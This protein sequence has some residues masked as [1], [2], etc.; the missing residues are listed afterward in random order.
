MDDDI[1]LE[2]NDVIDVYTEIFNG[3]VK[4]IKVTKEHIEVLHG[5]DYLI[6]NKSDITEIEVL[7]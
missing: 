5:N 6:I 1:L 4:I 3:V 7:G 2:K